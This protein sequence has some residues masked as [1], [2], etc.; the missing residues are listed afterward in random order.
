MTELT[1]IELSRVRNAAASGEARQVRERAKLSL[2]EL[3]AACEVDQSTIWRWET[4][5]R[6]PRGPAGLRYARV[7]DLL[8][9]VGT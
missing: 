1:A 3:G 4:G 9:E 7:L 6:R 8:R 5:R 2:S